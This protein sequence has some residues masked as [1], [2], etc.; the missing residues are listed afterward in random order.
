MC[1][2]LQRRAATVGEDDLFVKIEALPTGLKSW[3]VG[4]FFEIEEMKCAVTS[5]CAYT[6]RF[7]NHEE[8]EMGRAS[9]IR[10]APRGQLTEASDAG[11]FLKAQPG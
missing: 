6:L 7:A 11:F 8:G 1:L 10:H 5:R 3:L 4:T 9:R 2:R